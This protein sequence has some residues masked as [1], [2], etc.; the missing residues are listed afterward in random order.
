MGLKVENPGKDVNKA[1]HY[2]WAA[3]L[4]SVRILQAG[5]RERAA[6]LEERLPYMSHGQNTLSDFGRYQRATRLYMKSFDH[7]S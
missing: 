7:R 1:Q 6:F 4:F 3:I 5:A 2:C